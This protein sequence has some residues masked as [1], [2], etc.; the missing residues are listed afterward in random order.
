MVRNSSVIWEEGEG[1]AGKVWGDTESAGIVQCGPGKSSRGSCGCQEQQV[2]VR[3]K[4][5]RIVCLFD[6]ISYLIEEQYYHSEIE[7]L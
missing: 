2:E 7:L 6:S 1:G 3:A 4:K 5:C